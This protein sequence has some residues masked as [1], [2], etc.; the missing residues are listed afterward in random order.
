MIYLYFFS[1]CTI[2]CDYYLLNNELDASI[3][4]GLFLQ[5]IELHSQILLHYWDKI[6]VRLLGLTDFQDWPHHGN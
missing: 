5:F 1:F 4:V 2:F 6:Q 3:I